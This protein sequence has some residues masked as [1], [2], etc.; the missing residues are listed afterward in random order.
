MERRRKITRCSNSLR[1]LGEGGGGEGPSVLFAGEGEV[2]GGGEGGDFGG[3]EGVEGAVVFGGEVEGESG[4]GDGG[5]EGEGLFGGNCCGLVL[6]DG[7]GGEEELTELGTGLGGAG[8]AGLR[9]E[10]EGH[11][12]DRGAEE[13]EAGDDDDDGEAARGFRGGGSDNGAGWGDDFHSAPLVR[14]IW[15]ARVRVSG[16]G[17]LGKVSLTR[18][19]WSWTSGLGTWGKKVVARWVVRERWLG[20]RRSH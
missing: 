20:E 5:W 4:V 10:E 15:L 3:G 6:G 17:L 2:F 14:R 11:G 16:L 18:A 12:E 8:A 9:G 7:G 1:G 13:G 19:P